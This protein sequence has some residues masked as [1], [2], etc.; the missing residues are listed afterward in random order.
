[1]SHPLATSLISGSATRLRGLLFVGVVLLSTGGYAAAAFAAVG[2][3][4]TVAVVPGADLQHRAEKGWF[5]YQDPEKEKAAE[6]AMAKAVAPPAVLPPE[7]PKPD[8]CK[9][10]KTWKPSC[11]FVDPGKSFAW[12]SQERDA[13]LQQ[14][15][16]SP[17]DQKGVEAFQRYNKWVVD[18]AV[19]AA[20]TWEWNRTQ[21]PDLDPSEVA[22][23]SEFGLALAQNLKETNS[24]A[25]FKYIVKNG[26]MLFYFTREGC[27]FCHKMALGV[28]RIA[29]K[30][31]IPL[32]DA[33]IEG[34]CVDNFDASH[35]LPPAK[36][37]GP[38]TLLKVTVVPALIL[39]L[40][41]NTWIRVGNGLTDDETVIGRI[42]NFF[43]AWRTAVLRGLPGDNGTAPVDFDPKHA[44]DLGVGVTAGVGGAAQAATEADIKH[45]L[46]DK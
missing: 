44:P 3:V 14:M 23:I 12:Q 46:F 1:M 4:P 28:H 42:V 32:Y 31:G 39:Y 30:T 37:L 6:A 22:P 7:G 16:M 24:D 33:S 35:C 25:I 26:G 11:G 20:K 2:D 41:D 29:L 27:S 18:K 17:A 5:F 19:L 13:L 8:S 9:E 36:S 45:I 38:A 34:A 15:I 40:P 43:I 10:A 21:H